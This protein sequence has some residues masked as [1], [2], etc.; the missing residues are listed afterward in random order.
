V[1]LFEDSAALVGLAIAAAGVTLSHLTGDAK[2]D[3][4]ASILI[5]IVLAGVAF[6]LARESKGL[7]IGERADGRLIEAVRATF[8][9]RPEVTG[10][11]R[12]VTVHIAPERVFVAVDV[13]FHDPVAVGAIERLIADAEHELCRSWPEIATI[14]VKPKAG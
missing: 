10:V 12:I 13:D 5:G 8:A 4:V 6:L 2:W 7:L 11:G 3:G 9:D 1:V 14:Y